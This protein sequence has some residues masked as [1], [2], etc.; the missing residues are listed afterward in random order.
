[1]RG[2]SNITLVMTLALTIAASLLVPI[3]FYVNAQPQVFK[4]NFSNGKLD[5][6]SIVF[7]TWSVQNQRL[8]QNIADYGGSDNWYDRP[9]VIANCIVGGNFRIETNLIHRGGSSDSSGGSTAILFRYQ[10]W[11][12]TLFVIFHGGTNIII[13]KVV[14]NVESNNW[15]SFTYSFNKEYNAVVDVDGAEIDVYVDGVLRASN[16]EWG[17]AFSSGKIG[18]DTWYTAVTYDDILVTT[19]R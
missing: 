4:D 3:G 11:G 16:S 5:S 9:E 13:G 2:K 14:N 7:G 6:W 19:L 18:F 15:Y 12:N 17:S 1:M 8:V 10:D